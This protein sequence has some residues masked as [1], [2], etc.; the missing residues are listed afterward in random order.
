MSADLLIGLSVGFI[1]GS[2]LMAGGVYS[3]IKNRRPP[4]PSKVAQRVL[5]IALVVVFVGLLAF[6]EA[7][8]A[9]AQTATPYPTLNLPVD[10]IFSST[11]NWMAVLAPISALGIGI[12]LATKLFG[13]IGKVIGNAL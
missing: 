3:Y 4:K 2:A 8:G 7:S 6:V 11:N 1:I 5:S 12:L 10:A 13:Y 9:L